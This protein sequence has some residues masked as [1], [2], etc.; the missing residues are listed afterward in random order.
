MKLKNIILIV[1]MASFSAVSCA[2]TD[3]MNILI[4]SKNHTTLVATIKAGSLAH[5]LKEEGAYTI[6][7]A[8]NDAFDKLYPGK[9]QSLLKPE[10]K[11]ILHA[12]LAYH[13]VPSTL[14]QT[15]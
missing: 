2:Q 6:F 7:A 8:T 14:Q 15:L 9:L 12:T 5:A 3:V 1:A 11:A 10:N 13:I 4:T